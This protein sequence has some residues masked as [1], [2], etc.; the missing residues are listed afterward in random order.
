MAQQIG[1]ALVDARRSGHCAAILLLRDLPLPLCVLVA[2]LNEDHRT[3]F[4][5]L[6]VVR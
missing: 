6:I 2:L 4:E 3:I 1:I 5:G